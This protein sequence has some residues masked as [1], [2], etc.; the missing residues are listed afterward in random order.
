[1]KMTDKEKE[2]I[3]NLNS[4]TEQIELCWQDLDIV[5]N[6]IQKQEK[7]IELSNKVIDKRNQ[8]KLELAEILLKKDKIIDL[9]LNTLI[10]LDSNIEIVKQQARICTEE[11]KKEVLRIYERKVENGR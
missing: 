11:K 5:L 1:M 7:E 9:M 3:Q 10:G 4:L 6:L 8:E 2:A